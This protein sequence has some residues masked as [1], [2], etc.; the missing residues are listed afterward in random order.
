MATSPTPAET[1]YVD[2]GRA[3]QFYFEDPDWVRKTLMGSLF[4]LLALILVGLPFV[5]GYMVQV[6][7]RAARGA[8][9]PR[10]GRS[11]AGGRAPARAGARGGGGPRR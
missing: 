5:A 9:R 7:R 3:F 4:Y 8:G 6:T 11:R 10:P 2:F 1:T